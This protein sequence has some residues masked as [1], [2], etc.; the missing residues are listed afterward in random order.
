MGSMEG[1]DGSD[2][3]DTVPQVLDIFR[4]GTSNAGRRSIINI[5]GPGRESEGE[6][7]RE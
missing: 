2:G 1:G 3:R 5:L 4:D 6:R 7:E